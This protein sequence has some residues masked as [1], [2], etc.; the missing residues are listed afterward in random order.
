M[1][2]LVAPAAPVIVPYMWWRE[3]RLY[4]RARHRSNLGYSTGKAR[5]GK[6]IRTVMVVPAAVAVMVVPVAVAVMVI[7][8]AVAVMVV[9]PAVPIATPR[10]TPPVPVPPT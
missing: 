2:V 1:P 10:L 6:A 5:Q 8:A 9:P 4:N 7:P 3:R